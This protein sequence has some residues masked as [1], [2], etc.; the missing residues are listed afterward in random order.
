MSI[1]HWAFCLIA[2]QELIYFAYEFFIS[3]GY[4]K[5]LFKTLSTEELTSGY[6]EV[7]GPLGQ[8][9]DLYV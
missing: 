5:H 6:P 8:G 1:F 2:F 9:Y 7:S 4:Y 3:F